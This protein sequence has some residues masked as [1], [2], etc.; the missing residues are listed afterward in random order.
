[1][2]PA[3]DQPGTANVTI[4]VE[5]SDGGT[6]SDSFS[7]TVFD[8]K[9]P[10]VESWGPT[11]TRVLPTA[12]VMAT[13]SEDM[14]A[15]SIDNTTLKLVKRGSSTSVLATLSR[16]SEDQVVLGPTRNLT[17]GATYTATITTGATDAAAGIPL[18]QD[19]NT[20][21]NQPK[22]WTFKVRR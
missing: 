7:L 8:D 22:T 18:D 12:N 2:T 10:T 21:G 19:P 11:G 15:S 4:S 16:P 13:F 20:P 6:R 1:V 17:R 3:S 14:A 5:D 9:A